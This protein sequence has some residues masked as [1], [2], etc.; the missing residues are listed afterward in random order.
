MAFL[1]VC[2]RAAAIKYILKSAWNFRLIENRIPFIVNLGLWWD[3][4]VSLTHHLRR[5]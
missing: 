1:V 2:D 5:A 3:W 4:E